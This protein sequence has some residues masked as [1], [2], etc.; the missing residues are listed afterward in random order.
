MN[1]TD[2]D[3]NLAAKH[4]VASLER[5]VKIREK[6]TLKPSLPFGWKKCSACYQTKTVESFYRYHRSSDGRL[7]RCRRCLLNRREELKRERAGGVP[8]K[9]TPPV[10]KGQL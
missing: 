6:E 2:A 9:M 10:R 3:L 5:M 4:L 1:I 7:G 8:G